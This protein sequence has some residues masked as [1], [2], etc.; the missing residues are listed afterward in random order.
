MK[1]ALVIV[2]ALLAG[3]AG[4]TV[5]SS[6]LAP[7]SSSAA[8][9]QDDANASLESVSDEV[10]E[11]LQAQIRE[12]QGKILELEK[13]QMEVSTAR[14]TLPR[15]T[16][17][18]EEETFASNGPDP[19]SIPAS[20][21]TGDPNFDHRVMAVLEAKEE[22]ERQERRQRE[23]ERA[24][25]RMEERVQRYREELGL[26]DYQTQEMARILTD[27]DNQRR[28]YFNQLRANRDMGG[29]WDRESIREQMTALNENTN[30]QLSSILNQEQ[31]TKYE[32]GNNNWGDFFGG[33]RRGG[34][35]GNNGG[36][37]GRRGD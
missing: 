36:N 25:R 6:L 11:S 18:N 1:P 29:D 31:M 37:R 26:D 17:E 8:P 24:Q 13:N 28:D 7:E 27:A 12:L 33:G 10:T 14:A 2:L 3:L 30:T 22:Q 21:S 16:R 19:S 23:E 4:G 15:E 9:I 34:G 35:G 20:F 5:G 32:E